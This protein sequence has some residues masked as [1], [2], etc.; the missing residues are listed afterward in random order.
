MY[1]SFLSHCGLK[2][3]NRINFFS[4]KLK[5]TSLLQKFFIQSAKSMSDWHQIGY[6]PFTHGQL[7]GG[8]QLF[9]QK[10]STQKWANL[11][12]GKTE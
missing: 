8:G 4:E 1:A 7:F 5:E 2:L 11:R 9:G 3:A 12:L 10:I 6:L